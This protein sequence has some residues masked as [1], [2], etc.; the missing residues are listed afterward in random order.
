MVSLRPAELP[1][2]STQP[3]NAQRSPGSSAC[4]KPEGD[5]GEAWA[6]LVPV[7]PGNLLAHD[8]KLAHPAGGLSH[9]PPLEP[10]SQ[11]GKSTPHHNTS[12]SVWAQQASRPMWL[13]PTCLPHHPEAGLSPR[14]P[15]PLPGAGS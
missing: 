13:A 12:V 10:R 7:S 4:S 15:C 2:L 11:A 8:M 6:S 1:P 3:K 5:Y 9:G 14:H